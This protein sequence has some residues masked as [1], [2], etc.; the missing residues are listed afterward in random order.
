MKTR[1]LGPD[2]FKV[3]EIGLGCWQLGGQDFGPMAEETAQAIL[4]S[5]SQ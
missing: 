1:T 5:A 2:G 4:L 3:G